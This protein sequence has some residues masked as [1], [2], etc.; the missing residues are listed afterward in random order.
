M[1]TVLYSNLQLFS[2]C[3]LT[4]SNIPSLDS[5]TNCRL[6]S[7]CTSATC[8]LTVDTIN[9][10]IRVD[11][12]I[13]PCHQSLSIRIENYVYNTSLYG[14]QYGMLTLKL[15]INCGS[16]NFQ[17]CAQMFSDKLALCSNFIQNL[18]VYL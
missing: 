2:D 9:R 1:Q 7:K 15:F 11:L 18:L 4:T 8:C 6:L 12:E 17:H 16:I 3:T 5:I 14:F 10:T 13:D